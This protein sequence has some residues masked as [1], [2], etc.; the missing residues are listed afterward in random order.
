MKKTTEQFIEEAK[1]IH[2][3]KYDYSLVDYKNNSSKIKIRCKEDN[4]I[5]EQIP[6]N[7]LSGRNGCPFCSPS[8]RYNQET[9][10]K[11]CKMIHKNKYDYSKT[12]FSNVKNEITIICPV[13]GEFN[14]KARKHLERQD[15]PHC[16]K[17]PEDFKNEIKNINENIK[18][19]SDYKDVKTK[20]KIKCEKCGC[21]SERYP[22]DLLHGYGCYYCNSSVLEKFT[23]KW[24]IKSNIKYEREKTFR[25]C[26]DT[27]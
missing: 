23:E 5:F 27:I 8:P 1:K 17:E 7:H 2:G 9:F 21:E 12:L 19:L 24:L 18:I 26:K 14:Q 15:C 16:R 20:I 22:S 4:Y 11:K 13:H 6:E 25:E 3:D 10:I